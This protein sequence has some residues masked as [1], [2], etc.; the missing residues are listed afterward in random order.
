[1]GYHP[2]YWFDHKSAFGSEAELRSMIDAFKDKKVGIIEDV[3]I[4]HRASV[5]SDWLNF[6]EETYKEGKV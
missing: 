2:V 5:N 1:M 3:V 6:P 4:N